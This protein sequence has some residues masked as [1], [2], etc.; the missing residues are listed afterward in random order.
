MQVHS[1]KYLVVVFLRSNSV[2]LINILFLS[3]FDF[4]VLTSGLFGEE[5]IIIRSYPKQLLPPF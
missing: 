4:I 1:N 2:Y 3:K 5:I